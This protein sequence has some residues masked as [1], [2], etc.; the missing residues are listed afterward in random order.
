MGCVGCRRTRAGGYARGRGSPMTMVRGA[1]NHHRARPVV[2]RMSAHAAVV[3]S[4]VIRA[5]APRE[6]RKAEQGEGEEKDRRLHARDQSR[7]HAIGASFER[8]ATNDLAPSL[9]PTPG[10]ARPVH[11]RS[12]PTNVGQSPASPDAPPDRVGRGG[13]RG[14]RASRPAPRKPLRALPRARSRASRPARTARRRQPP[15]ADRSST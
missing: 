6:T 14:L 2:R 10:P 12:S 3:A 13:V 4:V 1:A 7:P 8:H 5:E 11:G 15:P 9:A